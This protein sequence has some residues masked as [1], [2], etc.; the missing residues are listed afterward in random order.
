MRQSG[1]PVLSGHGEFAKS[2]QLLANRLCGVIDVLPCPFFFANKHV[3][4]KAVDVMSCSRSQRNLLDRCVFRV[5]LV[6]IPHSGEKRARVTRILS[7][8]KMMPAKEL[9]P[10]IPLSLKCIPGSPKVSEQDL[11]TL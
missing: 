6:L 8:H 7:G 4:A 3:V 5:P 2:I 10:I 11:Y 9:P 1:G